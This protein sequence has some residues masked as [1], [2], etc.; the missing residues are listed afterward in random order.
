M[1]LEARRAGL[2]S[3]FWYVPCLSRVTWRFSLGI[4]EGLFSVLIGILGFFIVPSTPRGSK[5]LTDDEKEY[6]P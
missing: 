6:V 5:F 3:S 1:V 2:G 4:Q